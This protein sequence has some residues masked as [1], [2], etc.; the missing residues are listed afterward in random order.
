MCSFNMFWFFVYFMIYIILNLLFLI[1]FILMFYFFRPFSSFFVRFH[2]FFSTSEN[3]AS[4]IYNP[5]L[6]KDWIRCRCVFPV[7]W[8]SNFPLTFLNILLLKD[9]RKSKSSLCLLFKYFVYIYSQMDC[10]WKCLFVRKLLYCVKVIC[11]RFKL[12]I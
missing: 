8:I 11:Q 4:Q 7:M 10:S 1:P 5:G 12:N 9:C 2:F 6:L 3:I